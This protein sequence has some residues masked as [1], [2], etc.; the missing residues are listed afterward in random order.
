M[1][2]TAQERDDLLLAADFAAKRQLPGNIEQ[3]HITTAPLVETEPLS[4]AV[5]PQVT[6]KQLW[7]DGIGHYAEAANEFDN[8]LRWL[9]T[10]TR[11][12]F[13]P[14]H[15]EWIESL[16]AEKNPFT[17]ERLNQLRGTVQWQKRNYLE[18][19][20]HRHR[21]RWRGTRQHGR[22]VGDIGQ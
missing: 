7:G 8:F 4:G 21:K 10:Q 22:P 11:E 16:R 18:T 3:A 12:I 5:V 2:L 1:H 15:H 19:I 20:F 17:S 13:A 9:D 6:V 14:S